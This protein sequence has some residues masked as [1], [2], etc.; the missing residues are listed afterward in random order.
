MTMLPDNSLEKVQA[1]GH[2]EQSAS[3]DSRVSRKNKQDS[4]SK[5]KRRR[6][7]PT[8]DEQLEEEQVLRDAEDVDNEHIDFHA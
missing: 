1:P 3:I 8:V 5:N 4:Q 6:F 7:Q 2:I